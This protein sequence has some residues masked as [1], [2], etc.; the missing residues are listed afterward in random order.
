MRFTL[1]LALALLLA[2]GDDVVA[3]DA[4]PSTDSG[5]RDGGDAPDAG[6][7]PDAGDAPDAATSDADITGDA[8]IRFDAGPHPRNPTLAEIP[9]GSALDLGVYACEADTGHRDC[10]AITDYSGYVYDSD[11]HQLLM[12]GGGHSSTAR[13]DVAT[14]S[15][16][17]LTWS[18]AYMTTACEDMSAENING[19]GEWTNTGHPISAHTYDSLIYDPGTRRMLK[20]AN[21]REG[22]GATVANRCTT[23]SWEPGPDT[24]SHIYDPDTR[25]WTRSQH[26]PLTLYGERDP[27]SGNVIGVGLGLVSYDPR[28]DSVEVVSRTVPGFM[29]DG[30]LVHHPPSDHFYYISSYYWNVGNCPAQTPPLVV[31]ITLDREELASTT[32]E[33]ISDTLAGD[34]PDFG[35]GGQGEKGFAYD[36]RT[37]NFITIDDGAAWSLDVVAGRWTR[38]PITS[39]SA[40]GRTIDQ[41]YFALA[42]DP[43]D[44]VFIVMGGPYNDRRTW[45]YRH[46]E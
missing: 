26:G 45:A 34:V 18:S 43:T 29:G 31:E 46:S 41:V 22:R 12:F 39:I 30:T 16:D 33:D 17:T 15:F 19:F 6:N 4:G 13:T 28:D 1:G 32:M 38:T 37:G 25:S 20:L 40:E 3:V 11:R 23:F 7:A 36:P 27:I 35:C 10:A 8:G 44:G 2:C 14:F 9:V 5:L 24:R 21:Y 42:Y